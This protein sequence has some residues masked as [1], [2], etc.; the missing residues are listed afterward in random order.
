MLRAG[1]SNQWINEEQV[2]IMEPIL[3]EFWNESVSWTTARGASTTLSFVGALAVNRHEDTSFLFSMICEVLQKER[4]MRAGEG[5][6]SRDEYL[7]IRVIR[8][9]PG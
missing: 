5:S 3:G 8:S 4:E 6:N 9:S 1:G 2:G 7:D